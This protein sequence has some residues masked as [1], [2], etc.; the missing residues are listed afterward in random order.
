MVKGLVILL[1]GEPTYDDVTVAE[2]FFLTTAHMI[3]YLHITMNY[4]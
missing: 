1:I 3:I 4:M 2:I